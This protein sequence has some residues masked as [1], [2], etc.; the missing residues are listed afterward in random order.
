[1]WDLMLLAGIG[2]SDALKLAVHAGMSTVIL[3]CEHGFPFGDAITDALAAI[4]SAGGT[5]FVRIAPEQRFMLGAIADSGIHGVVLS[6]LGEIGEMEDACARLLPPPEG[7]RSVNPFTR[8]A[9]RMGDVALFRGQALGLQ[10]WAMA[11]TVG[12]LDA[13]TAIELTELPPATRH[14]WR[15]V[16]IGPY[17]LAAALGEECSPSNPKLTSRMLAVSAAAARLS[18]RCGLFARNAQVLGDWLVHGIK[19]DSIIVGYDRDIWAQGCEQ[20]VETVHEAFA[21]ASTAASQLDAATN[22]SGGVS[23]THVSDA[24]R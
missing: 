14:L 7:R 1:V 11:E 24:P 16:L 18:L 21:A 12:F 17:D 22:D 20:R 19:L 8:A 2:S 13:L 6:G 23:R 15:G 5:C 9:P 3:D 4:E 10:V